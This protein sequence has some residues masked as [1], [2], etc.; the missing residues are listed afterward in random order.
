MYYTGTPTPSFNQK[1]LEN[2]EKTRMG[3]VRDQK[4]TRLMEDPKITVAANN[5]KN[6]SAII[7]EPS[8]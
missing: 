2:Q 4:D 5:H 6:E 1:D 8:K 7:K 3:F